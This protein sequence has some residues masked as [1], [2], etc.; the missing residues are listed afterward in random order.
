MRGPIVQERSQVRVEIRRP[1]EVR[2]PKSEGRNPK[3]IRR[4]KSEIPRLRSQSFRALA[5]R[6]ILR[7]QALP[8]RAAITPHEGPA[9]DFGLRISFGF[10]PSDFGF[11]V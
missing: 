11:I 7:P 9:A 10:R 2:N 1:K 3:E 5:M 6:S 8:C 4:P